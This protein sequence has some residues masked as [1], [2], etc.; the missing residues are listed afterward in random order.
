MMLCTPNELSQ[1]GELAAG[2]QAGETRLRETLTAGG[3][4]N[5]RRDMMAAFE[6]VLEDRV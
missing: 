5:I 3:F 6:L 2:A 4:S 1:G